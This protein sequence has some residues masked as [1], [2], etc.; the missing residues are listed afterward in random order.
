M[1]QPLVLP[2]IASSARQS[3]S[4]L[5]GAALAQSSSRPCAA[6]HSLTIEHRCR[7]TR[8]ALCLNARVIDHLLQVNTARTPTRFRGWQQ[9]AEQ[10]ILF[11]G[12]ITRI[13]FTDVALLV[14]CFYGFTAYN[15]RAFLRLF[16]LFKRPLSASTDPGRFWFR[17]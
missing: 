15:R 14:L 5:D 8:M 9:V 16:D 11:A 1:S 7:G 3:P 13:R 10:R 2:P 4:V 12:Q 17:N 6:F